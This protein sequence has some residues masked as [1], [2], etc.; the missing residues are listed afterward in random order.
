[1]SPLLSVVEVVALDHRAVGHG[2]VHL[3]TEELAVAESAG[4]VA[5]LH[6]DLAAQDCGDRP[7]LD[8]TCLSQML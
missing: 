8:L 7:A 6:N 1:M 5:V 4:E 3:P 2:G